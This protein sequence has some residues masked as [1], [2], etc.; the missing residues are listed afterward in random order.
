M[1]DD[2]ERLNEMS[3]QYLILEHHL[4]KIQTKTK[5]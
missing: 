3:K 1:K 5:T 2:L 4:I